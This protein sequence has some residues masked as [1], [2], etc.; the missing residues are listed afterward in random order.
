MSKTRLR[1]PAVPLIPVDP[2]LN[3]WS[4]A[5]HLYDDFPRHWTGQRNALVGL[6]KIDGVWHRFMGRAEPDAERYFNEPPIIAQ[7]SAE[8]FPLKTSYIFENEK[9]RLNL[10]FT[11]PLLLDDLYI[12]SRPFSYI[13]YKIE[14]V[15]G[16]E[17][18][19]EIYID[20]SA[21][22]CVDKSLQKVRFSAH[23]NSI[24]CECT[25]Q[26]VLNRSGD[27]HRIDWGR[28]SLTSPDAELFITDSRGRKDYISGREKDCRR[29]T[30]KI[31]VNPREVRDGYPSLAS[32]K[33]GKTSM[34]GFVC[35]GYD[36]IKSI[37]Y[38]GRHLDAYWKKDGETFETAL[39]RAIKEH[40]EII[41]KCN[42]FNAE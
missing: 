24:F 42:K 32:T 2:Y 22:A 15:D 9:V 37:E 23:G 27:D 21:E 4:F 10:D 14:S 12:L 19:L 33:T 3:I 39:D 30:E 28:L 5:D 35:V 1:A 34:T 17:H 25:E 41:I 7:K 18:E 13:D 29:L 26:N 6:L 31:G 36:D 38:F 40:D 8:V 20:I 16:K 11:S